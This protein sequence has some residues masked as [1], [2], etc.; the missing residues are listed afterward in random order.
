MGHQPTGIRKP[1]QCPGW[2]RA[3]VCRQQLRPTSTLAASQ[4]FVLAHL[5]NV[6]V[7][8]GDEVV[9]VVVDL[10]RRRAG[11]RRGL[12]VALDGRTDSVFSNWEVGELEVPVGGERDGLRIPYRFG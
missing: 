2:K 8:G 12:V 11:L 1:G 9:D 7:D 3:L 6:W 5:G 4:I 10:E